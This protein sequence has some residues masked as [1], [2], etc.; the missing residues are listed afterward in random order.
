MSFYSSHN[1]NKE[2]H[3]TFVK[4]SVDIIDTGID[5]AN[6]AYITPSDKGSP[7]VDH[8]HRSPTSPTSSSTSSESSILHRH[9]FSRKQNFSINFTCHFTFHFDGHVKPPQAT[10]W[11]IDRRALEQRTNRQPSIESPTA[12]SPSVKSS[13]L[14]QLLER[15]TRCTLNKGD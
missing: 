15:S 11:S 4:I 13:C 10:F 6:D 14:R 3:L 8:R 12:A 1:R 2:I 7:L 5:N 9:L